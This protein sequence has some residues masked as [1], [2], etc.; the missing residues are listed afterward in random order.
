[1]IIIDQQGDII[2]FDK[3]ISI[4]SLDC[5]VIGV[6]EITEEYF[7]LG[8]YDTNKRAKEVIKEFI[9]AYQ[10]YEHDKVFYMPE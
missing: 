3:L 6:S 4:A 7:T 8:M 9:K 1:M 2:N 5:E 10:G